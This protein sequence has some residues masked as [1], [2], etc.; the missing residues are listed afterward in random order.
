MKFLK[1]TL[2]N[3]FAYD[4]LTEFDLS[5]TSPD[6]NI[7]LIWGRNGMGKTSFLRAM[8]LLFAGVEYAPARTV[9][10][11]PRTLTERQFVLGD[12]GAWSGLINRKSAAR[13]L[14]TGQDVTA[15]VSA[16][17]Q[18]NDGRVISA[19]RQWISSRNSYEERLILFDG[20]RM[21]GDAARDRL[22]DF[23]P[24]DFVDFFFFDGDDIMTLAESDERKPLDFDRLLRITFITALAEE[25]ARVAQDKQKGAASADTR[26]LIAEAE[27]VKARAEAGLDTAREQ[28]D[29]LLEKLGDDTIRLRRLQRLLETL[30]SGASEAQREGLETRRKE[31]LNELAEQVDI[32]ARDVPKSAPI[33]ANL[34][35]VKSALTAIETR[36]ARTGRAE[37]VFARKVVTQLPEWLQ[38]SPISLPEIGVMQVADYLATKIYGE[39]DVELSDGLF[40][41]L[42]PLRAEKLR[43]DLLRW[44]ARAEVA[45]Q[46]HVASLTIARRLRREAADLQEALF[47][48]EVGSQANLEQYRQ[49]SSEVGALEER[50]AENQQLRGRLQLQIEENEKQRDEAIN[51]IERYLQSQSKV[52]RDRAEVRYMNRI[53]RTLND[54]REELKVAI[55]ASLEERLTAR[56][57]ELVQHHHLVER[58]TIDDLY[59]LTFLDGTGQPVGRRSLSSGL[60]QLAAT[61]LLWAMK[62]IADTDMAVVIDTPLSRIDRQNQENMLRNYYPNLGEQVIILPTNSEIDRYKY[63]FLEDH[64]AVEYRIDN[65]TGDQA[66]ISQKSLIGD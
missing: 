59:T 43:D 18:T 36:L 60:K 35:L 16:T 2:D 20:E 56:F 9:G 64:V 51:Q 57:R 53:V 44:Q 32:I 30:R 45:Y 55:R 34:S 8:K 14:Q 48:I 50:I 42:E 17:W 5:K 61:A 23:L 22:G 38:A 65:D 4:I 66:R 33:I 46:T 25:L 41:T 24:P 49:I 62:D 12:G 26:K 6:R 1:I 13:S 39:L 28:L 15:R 37:E 47:Q 31:V 7:V 21:T 29:D 11:P 10:F 63:T 58:V 52:E 40:K 27:G 19:E 3:I 54:T